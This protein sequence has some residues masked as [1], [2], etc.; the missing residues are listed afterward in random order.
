MATKA[1]RLRGTSSSTEGGCPPPSTPGRWGCPAGGP[2][3]HRPL[4]PVRQAAGEGVGGRP[5]VAV[6][7]S[8]QPPQPSA[9]APWCGGAHERAARGP[10]RPATG[11]CS[12]RLVGPPDI[13]TEFLADL[14]VASPRSAQ[15]VLMAVEVPCEVAGG[16]GELLASLDS[17]SG[18]RARAERTGLLDGV[19]GPT[20]C[21]PRDDH[22]ELVWARPVGRRQLPLRGAVPGLAAGLDEGRGQRDRQVVGVRQ[23]ERRDGAE[24]LARFWAR[25]PSHM[26]G[27]VAKS[28][29]L[30]RAFP[31]DDAYRLATATSATMT[32]AWP[33]RSPPSASWSCR[34]TPRPPTAA[35]RRCDARSSRATT[36]GPGRGLRPTTVRPRTAHPTRSTTTCPRQAGT[37]VTE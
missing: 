20:W 35:P 12:H 4:D 11:R 26:L 30:R 22:G 37:R 8:L 18:R 31:D 24:H 7:T 23:Y 17:V 14:V 5:S 1:A 2:Q 29:A 27:K 32:P 9:P 19:D 13:D 10:R 21:G 16:L 25:M 3:A 36:P 33:A 15:R 6:T 28:M 34:S